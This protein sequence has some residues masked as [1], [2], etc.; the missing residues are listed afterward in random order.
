MPENINNTSHIMAYHKVYNRRNF[1]GT[2]ASTAFA[3]S[4]IPSHV[5][6]ANS[7]IQMAGIGVGGKGSSDIE[8]AGKVG[9]VVAICDIDG[10][11]LNDAGQKYP[12]AKKYFDFREMLTNMKGKIDA[13]TVSTPDH[14]HAP[15]ALMAIRQGV[16]VYCQKPLT[17]T[18]AEA[19]ALRIEALRHGVATQ[20][21]NQGTAEN[22]LRRGVEL[23]QSGIIGDVQEIHV[24]TNRPV[25]PQAPE[26]V[27]RPKETPAIPAHVRWDQFIG[28]APWRPYHEAYH[29]F[30]WRGWWDF[31]TGALGDMGCHTANMAFMAARLKYPTSVKAMSGEVNPETYPAWATVEYDFPS[32]GRMPA[33]KFFWYEGKLPNGQK[34]LPPQPL[35]HGENPPGS[36][37]IIVGTEGVL[38]SPND[39]GAAYKIFPK[40]RNTPM[41][42]PKPWIPRNGRGDL[43]MKE[44]W[45][46]AIRGGSPA[47]SN[48]EYAGILTEAILLGNVAILQGGKTLNWNGPAMKFTDN[49]AANDLLHKKFRYGWPNVKI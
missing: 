19:R 21:G 41:I 13:V 11:T 35:F 44:E 37:S 3:F 28:P 26:I 30:K 4:F 39:Y 49:D 10:G 46:S 9:K 36:G 42:N 6:G 23:I 22:G 12:G 29:P 24:W 14:T 15:A 5:W 27:G 43:G 8:N 48:F 34:N 7:T 17:H 1:I 40:N 16:H 32:R 33:C 45:A 31:G 2:S 47:L 38:Y 18:V 20:M 25:W